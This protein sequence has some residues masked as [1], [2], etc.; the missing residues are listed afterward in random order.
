LE[1]ALTTDGTAYGWTAR[2]LL[3]GSVV[4]SRTH[5]LDAL[6]TLAALVDGEGD[7]AVTD[8][9]VV[10]RREGRPEDDVVVTGEDGTRARVREYR[11]GLAH[12]ADVLLERAERERRRV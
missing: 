10:E 9:V 11:R 2:V 3:P 8:D 7:V 6:W 4:A 12:T 1:L 5:P